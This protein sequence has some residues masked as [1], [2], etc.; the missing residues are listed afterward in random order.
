MV[1]FAL[2]LAIARRANSLRFQDDEQSRLAVAESSRVVW[3]STFAWDARPSVGKIMTCLPLRQRTHHDRLPV[4]QTVS[5]AKRETGREWFWN[6][7]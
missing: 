1:S 4:Q 7:G 6:Q 2:Q 5:V 3:R